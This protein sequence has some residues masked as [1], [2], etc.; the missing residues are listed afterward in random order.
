MAKPRTKPGVAASTPE[1]GHGAE[2]TGPSLSPFPALGG[3]AH[4]LAS[5]KNA[6]GEANE[7]FRRLIFRHQSEESFYEWGILADTG[8]ILADVPR[9][10][11]SSLHVLSGLEPGRRELVMVPPDTFAL[12]VEEAVALETMNAGHDVVATSEVS[13][14][15]V[16]ALNLK[17][18]MAA[19]VALRDRVMGGLKSALGDAALA[20]VRKPAS[21][22]SSPEALIKGL[23]ALATFI[24]EAVKKTG[25]D[26]TALAAFQLGAPRVAELRAASASIAKAS[27]VTAATGKRVSKRA[28]DIQ[29]GRVLVLIEIVHRAF[30]LA[31]RSDKAILMPELNRLSPLFGAKSGRVSGKG[32]GEEQPVPGDGPSQAVGSPG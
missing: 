24:E 7:A 10:V 30:R 6:L 11:A 13:G 29:D 22:A 18:R 17:H 8:N 3:G 20:Q 25:D 9:F 31:R 4:D 19:G 12:L 27:E 1:S 15:A 2:P 16:R 23:N 28:L 14:K 26:A 21:D 32:E 5:L